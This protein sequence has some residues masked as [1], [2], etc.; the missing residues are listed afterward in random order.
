MQVNVKLGEPFEQQPPA[1]LFPFDQPREMGRSHPLDAV[2]QQDMLSS[3]IRY[4]DECS[5]PAR[6][7]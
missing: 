5:P 2:G 7:L 3:W 4:T 1:W 6:S